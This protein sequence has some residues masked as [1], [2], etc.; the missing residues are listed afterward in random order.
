M[1]DMELSVG[2]FP[3]QGGYQGGCLDG[4]LTDPDARRVLENVDEVTLE[5]LGRPLLKTLRDNGS[6]N[7]DELFDAEPELVQVAA[8]AVSVALFEI[9]RARGVAPSILLGHSFGE[10]SAL[11]CAG[12]LTIDEGTRIICHRITVLREH[13]TSGG[14]MLALSCDRGRV[15]QILALLPS[16]D[17]VVAVANGPAQTA[18]SGPAD[19]IGRVA[20]IA[21]AIGVTATRLRA[22]HPFHNALLEPAR[23][24]FA[25][26]VRGHRSHGF[27]I[28]VYSPILGRYYR[29]QDDLGE[30]LA[31]HLVAPVEFGA[32]VERGHDAGARI[33]V[34]VGAGRVL[35]NLVRAQY[36]AA[37]VLTPL[38]GSADA[39]AGAVTFLGGTTARTPR[40]APAVLPAP[41][42]VQEP[43]PVAPS[44]QDSEPDPSMSRDDIEA[45]VRKLYA[46]ALDYPEEVFE[47]DAE[48]EADLGVDS[49][50]Q[51]ELMARL[52]D[53][54]ELGPRPDGMRMSDYRTFGKVIDF[55]SG[56]LPAVNGAHR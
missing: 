2:L 55:V 49:V 27:Q 32:A 9:F 14:R 54:F 22:P 23:R 30:L 35:T 15:E 31:A 33:W 6:L 7:D 46:D 40:T 1:P 48:L 13:D 5:A 36:P 19:A 21:D 8:F 34:E 20:R 47:P 51:T 41:V 39:L 53:V 17:A 37:T 50:K 29:E 28:P 42:P 18:V 25:E 45:K 56:S 26:R 24:M 52:G 38:R 3:G 4:L 11:V 16:S 43:A 12:A 10:I 44:T